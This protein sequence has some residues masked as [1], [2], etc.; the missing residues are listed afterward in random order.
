MKTSEQGKPLEKQNVLTMNVHVGCLADAVRRIMDLSAQAAGSYVCV[1][2]VH[3]CMETFDSPDFQKV[4]NQADLVVADGKP[5]STAQKLLGHHGASQVR[6]Q[7]LVHAL[8]AVSAEKGLRI[9][10]FGGIS[11]TLLQTVRHR[12]TGLYPG[13]KIHYAFSPPFRALTPEEDRNVI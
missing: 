12:L 3:M 2:N 8:C 11:T 4:V 5:I 6:G 10:F 1:S 9:G 13:L 7:D